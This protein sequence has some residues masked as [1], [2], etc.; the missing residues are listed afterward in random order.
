M[1]KYFFKYRCVENEKLFVLET[2]LPGVWL[3]PYCAK[4]IKEKFIW[5]RKQKQNKT[6][7]TSRLS[8]VNAFKNNNKFF[9]PS[10][11]LGDHKTRT[12]SGVWATYAINLNFCFNETRAILINDPTFDSYSQK[13][14]SLLS[15]LDSVTHIMEKS[16]F[17]RSIADY[18]VCI[19]GSY[20]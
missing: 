15:K 19:Q 1:Q 8:V 3:L 10:L 6:K 14:N 11:K 2:M 7:Q 17:L 13:L 9:F 4:L 18:Y 16:V 12:Y 5:K 20:F